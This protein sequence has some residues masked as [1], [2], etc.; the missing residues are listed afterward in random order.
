V[1][2]PFRFFLR[3]GWETIG[4]QCR[5]IPEKALVPEGKYPSN[6]RPLRI[7]PLKLKPLHI[8]AIQT[9]NIHPTEQFRTKTLPQKR[10]S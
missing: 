1:P 3:N 10:Y 6:K 9:K 5:I 4:A 2:H 7:S 8:L